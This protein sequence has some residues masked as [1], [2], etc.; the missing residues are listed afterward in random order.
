MC[1]MPRLARLGE[2]DVEVVVVGVEHRGAARLE[3][4]ENLGLGLG[5]LAD[6]L[7]E[8]EMR[9]GDRGDHRDVRPHQ[10]HQR[11]DLAGV[12]HADLEHA[13]LRLARQARQ[14]QRHAPVIVEAT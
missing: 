8:F 4:E 1:S 7:E 10:L 5:D 6:R 11:R 3:A 13:V 14:H 12:V 9:R 2:E